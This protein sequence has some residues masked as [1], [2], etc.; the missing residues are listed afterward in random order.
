MFRVKCPICNGLLTVDTRTRKIV[1]HTSAK[2]LEKSPEERLE[3]I[4]DGLE[5]AKSERTEK[6]ETARQREIE[7][8]KRV[9]DLFREA[10]EKAREGDEDKP[11][12]PVWD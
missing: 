2:D 10:K 4:M 5:K 9:N 8:K 6:L 7:R 1:G 3:T 12:G 11:L